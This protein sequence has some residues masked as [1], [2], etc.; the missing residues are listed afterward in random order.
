MSL[1]TV[2]II[3]NNFNYARFLGDAIGSALNQT[4][5]HV[6]VIVVDDGST[7]DS[8]ALIE[9]YGTRV[10]PLLKENRG[11]ASAI[12]AGF[13]HGRADIVIFLD[14]DDMLVPDIA[15]RVALAFARDPRLAKVQYPME[16]IDGSGRRTGI[17]K[18]PAH[19]PL[20]SGDLREQKVAFPFD[21]AWMATSGNAFAR[22]SL[23]RIMPIPEDEFALLADWYLNHLAPFLGRLATLEAIGAYYRVHGANSYEPPEAALDLDHVRR[24]IDYTSRVRPYLER[25]ALEEGFAIPGGTVL[26]V[27]DVAQRLISLR[28][29]SERHPIPGDTVPGLLASGIRATHRRFDVRWPMRLLFHMW[30]VA[31]AIAPKRVARALGERFLVPERRSGLNRVLRLLHRG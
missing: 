9:T 19:V 15:E 7:D 27:S 31:I 16:V 3:V 30:F 8:R 11:Q 29:E 20:R 18:P 23:N 4:H 1:P 5:P 22:K 26:S 21:V 13:V 6:S 25:L 24:T 12:N 17:R 28:V 2:D 10:Q 14:S